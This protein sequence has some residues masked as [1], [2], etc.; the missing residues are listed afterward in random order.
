MKHIALP[1]VSAAVLALPV[2]AVHAQQSGAKNP[3][4]TK[5]APAKKPARKAPAKTV[6]A[7]EANTPVQTPTDRLTDAEMGIAKRVHTGKVQCELGADVTV[8][9]DE[10]NPGFFH[11]S[12]G[13]QRFFMHPVESRTGAIRLEDIRTGAMLLQLGNKSMLMNQK[14]GQRIA[15]ECQSTEQRAFAEQMKNS[16]GPGLLDSAPQK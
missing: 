12:T 13:K 7:V 5:K 15:D 14:L 1:L 2:G 9:A 11:V 8:A 6:K 4:A 10:K 16:G 3:A